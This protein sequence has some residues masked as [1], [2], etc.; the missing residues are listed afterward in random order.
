[1]IGIPFGL[2]D[3][4]FLAIIALGIFLKEG[5]GIEEERR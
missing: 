3:T 4:Y 1:L 5:S 2:R